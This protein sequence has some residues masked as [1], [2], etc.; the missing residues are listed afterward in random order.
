MLYC[1]ISAQACF[2]F[3]VCSFIVFAYGDSLN[4]FWRFIRI[5]NPGIYI[6]RRLENSRVRKSTIKLN[7]CS[8]RAQDIACHSSPALY[9]TNKGKCSLAKFCCLVAKASC[10]YCR[11]HDFTKR[12]CL[13]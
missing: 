8:I 6:N 11:R 5:F 10:Y 7:P 1:Q 3:P 2:L 12:P 13:S 4:S 9:K